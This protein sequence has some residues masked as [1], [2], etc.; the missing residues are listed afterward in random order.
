VL[1]DASR[2][3]AAP[4]WFGTVASLERGIAASPVPLSIVALSQRDAA[5]Q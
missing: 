5:V 3:V 1:D 2:P 4:G